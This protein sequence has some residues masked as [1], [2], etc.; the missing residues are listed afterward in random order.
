[1]SNMCILDLSSGFHSSQNA[2]RLARVFKA[3]SLCRAELQTYYDGVPTSR[4]TSLKLSAIYPNPTFVSEVKLPSL[5][6]RKFMARTGQPTSVLPKLGNTITAMYIAT[7]GDSDQEVIV[8]FTA[9]YNK[10]A[11]TLLADAQF[12]PKLHF[13]ERIVGD[14]YMVV[15]DRVKGKTIWQ[16]CEDK[17]DIPTIVADQVEQAVNVLHMKGIV[18]GDLRD[19]NILYAQTDGSAEGKVFLVDFD[20]AHKDGEGRYPATL[21]RDGRWEEGVVPYGTMR[22]AHDIWQVDRLKVLCAQGA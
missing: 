20:W 12:A 3:V 13:C 14:L 11:H 6:Y 9:R 7:L 19:N 15:M 4:D 10:E 16:L 17:T 1:M 22:K 18:F 8:K 2:V 5:V 21:N